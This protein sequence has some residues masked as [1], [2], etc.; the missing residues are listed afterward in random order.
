MRCPPNVGHETSG[1]PA[2]TVFGAALA[3]AGLLIWALTQLC[4]GGRPTA[5]PGMPTAVPGMPTGDPMTAVAAPA[6]DPA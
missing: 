1:W 2:V 5:V 4:T 6:P 3:T